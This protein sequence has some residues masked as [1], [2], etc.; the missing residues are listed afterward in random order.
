MAAARWFERIGISELEKVMKQLTA[1]MVGL[2][3]AS[4]A[5]GQG[6]ILW[7]EAVNGPL[8]NDFAHP[9]S[10]STMQMGSNSV[11]GATEYFDFGGNGAVAP[12]YFS[13]S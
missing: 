11:R 4:S 10:L 6:T 12:D 13:R 5:Y 7:D 2:V 8:S 1:L 9:T 3:L